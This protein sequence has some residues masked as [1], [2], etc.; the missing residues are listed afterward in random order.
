MATRL[1]HADNTAFSVSSGRKCSLN[2]RGAVAS[3]WTARMSANSST[4]SGRMDAERHS[5]KCRACSRFSLSM[6]DNDRAYVPSKLSGRSARILRILAGKPRRRLS[7]WQMA[8]RN[9]YEMRWVSNL[10]HYIHNLSLHAMRL[11]GERIDNQILVIFSPSPHPPVRTDN[12]LYVRDYILF[13]SALI[14][15]RE[16]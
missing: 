16:L 4:R 14:M 7:T 9:L 10:R 11:L 3:N 2:E 12:R 13:L 1:E 8:Y 5:N 6:P 15:K